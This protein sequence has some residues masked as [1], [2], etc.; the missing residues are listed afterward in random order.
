[1]TKGQFYI[2]EILMRLH[3]LQAEWQGSDKNLSDFYE[4]E[5]EGDFDGELKD[6]LVDEAFYNRI[7]PYYNG[8][9]L[10]WLQQV[11]AIIDVITKEYM[12]DNRGCRYPSVELSFYQKKGLETIGT[13]RLVEAVKEYIERFEFVHGQPQPEQ[14]IPEPQ[15]IPDEL[16]T[17]QGR[18][19][20][21]RTIEGGFCDEAY[22]WLKTKAL[23]AYYGD[24][25][26][27]YLKIGKGFYDGREKTNWKPFEALF[28]DKNGGVISNLS[29]ARNDYTKTGELPTGYA[30]IDLLFNH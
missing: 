25:A 7:K 1:M 9:L 14:A 8:N 3:K 18:E 10:S 17:E 26:S 6:A 2:V 15:Q 23:L 27:E 24:K 16:N 29:G 21:R 11:K 30:N 5:V 13:I 12:E 28:R 19:L 4:I 20:L 22:N